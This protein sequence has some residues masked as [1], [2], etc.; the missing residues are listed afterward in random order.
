VLDNLIIL[1]GPEY[2][3]YIELK[4]ILVFVKKSFGLSRLFVRFG[5]VIWSMKNLLDVPH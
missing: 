4:V 3:E 2:V 5:L 1:Q